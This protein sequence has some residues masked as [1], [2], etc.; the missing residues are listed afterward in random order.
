MAQSDSTCLE[1][2]VLVWL[3]SAH[4]FHHYVHNKNINRSTLVH[5]TKTD[6]V[7]VIHCSLPD[8]ISVMM[9]NLIA[10]LYL[11]VTILQTTPA[12]AADTPEQLPQTG[13]KTP[14]QNVQLTIDCQEKGILLQYNIKV[15]SYGNWKH[16]F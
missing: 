5:C 7:Q 10:N 11:S 14:N 3:G 4:N 2:F 15:I 8:R 13:E 16:I 1:F 6:R 9:V 12:A